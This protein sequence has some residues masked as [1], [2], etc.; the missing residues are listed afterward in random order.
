MDKAEQF[1]FLAWGKEWG[2]NWGYWDKDYLLLE[3]A[4]VGI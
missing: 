3:L 1:L 2:W 4:K